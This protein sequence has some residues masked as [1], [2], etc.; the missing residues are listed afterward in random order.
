MSERFDV[1]VVGGGHNGLVCAAYL[2]RA[3]RK[4]LVLEAAGEVGGAAITREFAPGFSVS[5]CA[6][7]LFMLNPGIVSD[8]GLAGHGLDTAAPAMETLA[9]S[10]DGAHV[11]IAGRSVQGE[12]IGPAERAV[13][14]ALIDRLTRFAGVLAASYEETPPRLVE[15]SWRDHF[16]LLRT[17][18][19][20]RRLGRDDMREL[21][22]IGAINIY[23]VVREELSSEVLQGALALDAVLGTR[24]GPRSPNTVLTF[25]HRLTGAAS[26]A[27][28]CIPRGGMG[29]VSRALAGAAGA[30]GAVIRTGTAVK[31]ILLADG[32]AAGVELADGSTIEAGCV[33]SN[34]DPRTTFLSLVGA[35]NLETDFV[36]RVTCIRARGATAKLHLALGAL[37]EFRGVDPAALRSRI[38]IAPS[39]DY[40]ERAFDDAKFG[41]FAANPALE[42]TLPSL[43]DPALAPAGRHVL[44]AAVAYAPCAP[45]GNDRPDREGLLDAALGVLERYAPGIRNSIEH[46][47]LLL[48]EDLEREF[49]MSGGHWH[50]AEYTF[51]QFMMLR[52]V[53]GAAQYATPVP[54]LWLCGA[55]T[56]P[57][58]GVSGLPGRN[59]A[60][61]I[62]RRGA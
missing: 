31:R 59:A 51:D 49:R 41:G 58:G 22:R 53:P 18:L 47:E 26:G 23:D 50:H 43:H 3:G 37:P 55:G 25:L 6:H 19:R 54:G 2:A 32:R 28:L 11:R 61:E 5:P 21:L 40:V 45:Q 36:R 14:T 48:P 39:P 15:G 35:R 20:V 44:S 57:G 62:L 42:I 9:L 33:V 12:G 46:A 34:A 16:T 7:L 27:S 38:V 29:A 13:Y 60:R 10:E 17:A 52:P 56:H 24:L 4:V 1:I 8:L 30:A